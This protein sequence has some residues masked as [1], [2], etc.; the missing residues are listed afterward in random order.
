MMV[1]DA[2]LKGFRVL[3]LS[4]GIAGPYAACILRQQGADV[5]KLEPPDG[6][7]AR[8]AGHARHDF[9]APV[10]AYNAGKRALCLD[11]R[12]PPGVAAAQRIAGQV[13]LLIQNFRPGVTERLGLG[14][15]ALR[16]AN[17]RLVYVSI[18]GFGADGPLADA[19]ATDTVM[20]ATSGMMW[21]NR[22]P[23]GR[24]RRI[25]MHLADMA[26][27]I[28]ASQMAVA[29]LLQRERTGAGMHLQIS[30]LQACAALQATN[31]LANAWHPDAGDASG[32][33]GGVFATADGA[34]SLACTSDKMFLRLCDVL[35]APEWRTDARFATAGERLRHADEL[36]EQTAARLALASSAWWTERLRRQ[37]VLHSEI[38]DYAGFVAHPQSRQQGI[39]TALEQPGI[40]SLPFARHPGT[41]G[42]DAMPPAP[43]RGQD[44]DAVLAGFGFRPDEVAALRDAGVL[45]DPVAA[46]PGGR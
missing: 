7:W 20:Q 6:D 44:N 36:N 28:Y 3:D 15:S 24:A 11:L 41:L 39:F 8:K 22:G 17:P 27:A 9:T 25:P 1:L 45:I 43:R 2:A 5:V 37:D 33:P 38:L 21:A 23:D 29:G 16:Q 30:L 13:D 42:G 18:S 26:T 40:G 10:L 34:I 32:A 14:E 19:P 4:Q 31:I 12:K 35:E 46:A